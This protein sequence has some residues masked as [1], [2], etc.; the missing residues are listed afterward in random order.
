MFTSGARQL[1]EAHITRMPD[2]SIQSLREL[3]TYGSTMCL[4]PSD[5]TEPLVPCT[6][7]TCN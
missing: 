1:V 3:D 5:G 6:V 4:A 2:Q 7:N